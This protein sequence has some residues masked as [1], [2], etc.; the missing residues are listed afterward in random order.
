MSYKL[1]IVLIATI[2]I[3]SMAAVS[4]DYPSV[5][6]TS[7]SSAG[8]GP[9]INMDGSYTFIVEAPTG[10][11]SSVSVVIGGKTYPMEYSNTRWIVTISGLSSGTIYYYRVVTAAGVIFQGANQKL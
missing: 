11:F 6:D 7:S 5:V 3:L 9:E 2:L 4:A 10:V 8:V 1:S